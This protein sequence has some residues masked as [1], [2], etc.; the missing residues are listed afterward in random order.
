MNRRK[1]KRVPGGFALL[2]SLLFALLIPGVSNGVNLG[3]ILKGGGI[4]VIVKNYGDEIN[5][6]INTLLQNKKVEIKEATKVV[7]IISGGKGMYSGAAQVT[8]PKEQ[9]EKVKGVA[10]VESTVGDVRIKLLVPISARKFSDVARVKGV[11]VSALIDLK[12]SKL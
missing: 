9:V 6:A 12:V 2:I 11:G 1:N 8:G 7:P 5:K 3:D 10:Q 4:A